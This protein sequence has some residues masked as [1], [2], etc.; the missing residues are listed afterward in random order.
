MGTIVGGQAAIETFGRAM[1]NQ[2]DTSQCTIYGCDQGHVNF[3]VHGNFLVNS[4]NIEEVILEKF[5]ETF[6]MS[7]NLQIMYGADLRKSNFVEEGSSRVINK[8]GRLV[9]IVHQFDKDSELN[10]AF[11]ENAVT[12]LKDWETI[13]QRRTE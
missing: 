10:R 7:L 8:E 5:G 4:P 6:V 9:A 2:W 11:D 12:F 1:V 3:L 13:K